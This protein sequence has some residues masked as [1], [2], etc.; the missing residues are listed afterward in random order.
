MK[1]EDPNMGND[2]SKV[3]K[4]HSTLTDSSIRH[5]HP[6]WQVSNLSFSNKPPLVVI[7]LTDVL[8]FTI[9]IFLHSYVP[10]WVWRLIG[11]S[12]RQPSSCWTRMPVASLIKSN[13]LRGSEELEVL[14]VSIRLKRKGKGK[15][16]E[17]TS[18]RKEDQERNQSRKRRK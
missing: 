11:L 14:S 5:T 15:E 10:L 3:K 18:R 7:C 13:S 9:F 1:K 2:S 4:D 12:S 8:R 6:A 16:R 17:R